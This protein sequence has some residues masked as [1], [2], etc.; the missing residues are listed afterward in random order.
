MIRSVFLGDPTYNGAYRL[1]VA[2]GIHRLGGLHR[3]VSLRQDIGDIDKQVREARP[4]LVFTHMLLWPPPGALSKN[5]LLEL[6][7]AWRKGWGA[8]IL[9][10]D[11]GPQDTSGHHRGSLA[12]EVDL[13]LCNHLRGV[14]P[15]WQ[16]PWIRWPYAAFHQDRIAKPHSD[17]APCR[18]AFAGRLSTPSS[19]T[20]ASISTAP[21]GLYSAR[22]ACLQSLSERGL[23]TLFP[24]EEGPLAGLNTRLLTAELAASAGGILGF[25]RPEVAGWIDSRVFQYTGAGGLLLHDDVAPELSGLAD[26]IHYVQLHGRYDPDE[27]E[28]AY[29]DLHSRPV[30]PIRQ[31]AFTHIQAH[32]TWVHRVQVV[33]RYFFLAD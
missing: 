29:H 5:D 20:A 19:S 16:I 8:R 1:G 15:D 28:R 17:F 33:L 26:G 18:L 13:V 11:G 31:A 9:L 2:Q 21:S 7:C 32:H 22:T 23:L 10:H 25:G 30:T 12:T 24:R 14:P 6:C 27:I 4:H 3:D